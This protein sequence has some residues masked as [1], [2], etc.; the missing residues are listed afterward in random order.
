MIESL[1]SSNLKENLFYFQDSFC[2]SGGDDDAFTETTEESF[3]ELAERAMN[4]KKRKS[5]KNGR[6]SVAKRRKVTKRSTDSNSSE[7]ET[8][9]L[10]KQI[11]NE[12]LDLKRN[13][14]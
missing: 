2:V 7:D 8:E 3:L 6:L 9:K 12:S 11:I 5:V 4:N 14:K 10:R 1:F 13:K